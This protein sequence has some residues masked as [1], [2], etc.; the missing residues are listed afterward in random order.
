MP[1]RSSTTTI[2]M[3]PSPKMRRYQIALSS[4]AL[5]PA[6]LETY[7]AAVVVTDH[8]AVDYELVARHVPIVVDT[9]NVYRQRAERRATI[10][11]A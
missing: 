1:E 5:E 3:C 9:R 4:V 2:P 7:D 6:Q 11:K 10:V 8:D